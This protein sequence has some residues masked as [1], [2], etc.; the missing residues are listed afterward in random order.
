MMASKVNLLACKVQVSSMQ[1]SC[2]SIAKLMCQHAKLMCQRAKFMHWR[3]KVHV[4]VCKAQE[5][6]QSSD[7]TCQSKKIAEFPEFPHRACLI[8]TDSDYFNTNGNLFVYIG[9]KKLKRCFR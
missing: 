2:A 4:S 3:C 6:M 9:R 5:C 8:C 1:S 7:G